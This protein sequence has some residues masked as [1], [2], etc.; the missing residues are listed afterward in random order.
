MRLSVDCSSD[1]VSS[2]QRKSGAI[3][4][5]SYGTAAGYPSNV[6][7][8]FRFYG[9]DQERVRIVFNDFNLHYPDGDAAFP[10]K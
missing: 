8:K 5:P 4:S 6:I 1:V 3:T 7:C 10:D 9:T 2:E